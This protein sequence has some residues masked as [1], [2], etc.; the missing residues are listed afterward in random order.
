MPSDHPATQPADSSSGD[1]SSFENGEGEVI[2]RK[3]W[4]KEVNKDLRYI[5]SLESPSGTEYL[6][7]V[8]MRGTT[9]LEPFLTGGLSELAEFVL[10][11]LQAPY[12]KR[13]TVRKVGVFERRRWWSPARR[14][15]KVWVATSD[16]ADDLVE[17]LCT[18]IESGTYRWM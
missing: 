1:L 18:E 14:Q 12:A 11:K 15:Y 8:A 10:A 17:E 5:I 2:P 9:L 4:P 7:A 6:V 13:S 3:F 16:D